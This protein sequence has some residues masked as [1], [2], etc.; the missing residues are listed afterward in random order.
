MLFLL[1]HVRQLAGRLIREWCDTLNMDW[2]SKVPSHGDG[3]YSG[4]MRITHAARTHPEKL[5]VDVSGVPWKEG[6]KWFS[7]SIIV[8]SRL[9]F[10]MSCQLINTFSSTEHVV[11]LFKTR[12]GGRAGGVCIICWGNPPFQVLR[13]LFIKVFVWSVQKKKKK[14]L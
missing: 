1:F 6:M 9:Q 2:E 7:N 8:E 14:R 3:A 10:K 13:C 5:C 11:I 4:V 12:A